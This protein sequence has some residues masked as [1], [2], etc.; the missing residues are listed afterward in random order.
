[1][2]NSEL[3]FVK[4]KE[5]RRVSRTKRNINTAFLELMK[6]KEIANIT[7]TELCELAD[8]NRKTFYTYF[9]NISDVLAS[10][11]N[12]II[13]SFHNQL[14]KIRINKTHISVRDIILCI[15]D[16]LNSNAKFMHQLIQVDSLEGLEKKVK[17]VIKEA[18]RDV[19]ISEYKDNIELSGL[20]LE[21]I[22]SGAVSM[23][24]Q[25]FTETNTIPLK[26][27]TELTIGLVHSNTEYVLKLSKKR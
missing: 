19:L 21:Y 15:G 3:N 24:I 10:L 8:I 2:K 7:I 12:E 16:L 18:I 13:N 26:E 20:T 25:W 1:M 5:D 23:Y 9:D 14:L 11:E 22:V 6:Q 17:N 4:R 27:L